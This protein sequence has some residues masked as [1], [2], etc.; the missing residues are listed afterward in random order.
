MKMQNAFVAICD[1]QRE[2][3]AAMAGG[4]VAAP[5]SYYLRV[6]E[7][8]DG[9]GLSKAQ[10]GRLFDLAASRQADAREAGRRKGHASG[11]EAGRR[12]GQEE[13]IA[14]LRLKDLFPLFW[15]EIKR[16]F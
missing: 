14:S 6:A 15:R 12:D 1:C 10:A 9:F 13:A 7:H 4:F 2:M 8:M 5:S 11:I 3:N 16:L